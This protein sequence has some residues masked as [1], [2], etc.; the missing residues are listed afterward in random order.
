MAAKEIE[1]K[2]LKRAYEV[3]IAAK[4]IE[5]RQDARLGEIAKTVNMKG[6]RKGKAPIHVVKAQYGDSVMGEIVEQAVNQESQKVLNDNKI[7]PAMQPK[8]EITSFAKGEALKFKMEVEILPDFDVMDVKKL[9]LTKPVVDV[10]DKTLEEALERIASQNSDTKPI[11]TNR[12]AKKGDVAVIDFDGSVDGKKRDGMKG[13]NHNLELGGGMFIPG[14]EDQLIG[15]KAG[16]D[17]TVNVTFP[18]NYGAEDLAGKDAVFEVKI[19]E[20]REPTEAKVNDDLAKKLGLEDLEAL[21]NILREQMASEYE[22]FSR[23]KLKRDLLDQLDAGHK[24]EL[25]AM[26]VEQENEMIVKQME[27]ERHQQMHAAGN[28]DHDCQESHLTDDEKA[29][30]R[31]IAERRVRLGLV[32]SEIG[33]SNKVTVNQQDLQQAVIAEAKKY[34]GQEAQVFEFYQKNKQALESLRAPL[35]EEKVVDFIFELAEVKEKKVSIEELTAPDED[36]VI[37]KPKTKKKATAK[38]DADKKPAAKKKTESKA[39]AKK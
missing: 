5:K 13:E 9:K 19:H 1:N 2:G 38:K 33:T 26:M 28:H 24:F 14:F 7:K 25:P 20:L 21:K 11:K 18:E 23:M 34:P 35:F 8:I 22:Q 17:V 10:D 3:E 4:D 16:D 39:K 31:E 36:D 15:K 12:A 37:G 27:Q 32:L 6:F 30:L 29:E